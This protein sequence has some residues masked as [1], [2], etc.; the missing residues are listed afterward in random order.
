MSYTKRYLEDLYYNKICKCTYQELIENGMTP[1]EIEYIKN[2][3]ENE[4][5]L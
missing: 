3:F 5:E 4:E 2:M 1:Y